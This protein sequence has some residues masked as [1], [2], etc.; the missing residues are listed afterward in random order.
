M[1]EPDEA[2]G[3]VTFT[4]LTM[5]PK[6][7]RCR[8]GLHHRAFWVQD[9]FRHPRIAGGCNR[10][11]RTLRGPDCISERH[12]CGVCG[13]VAIEIGWASELLGYDF[14]A[15]KDRYRRQNAG[16]LSPGHL[17][18]ITRPPVEVTE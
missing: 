3:P 9:V 17:G 8:F 2:F 7:W 12:I 18:C 16:Q 10:C 11:D 15:A 5:E 4:T 13:Q 1:S 14:T 6:S